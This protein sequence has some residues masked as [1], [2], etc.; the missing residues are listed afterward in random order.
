MAPV[1]LRA[2]L[3]SGN[4]AGS[5]RRRGVSWRSRRLERRASVAS[6]R[7]IDERAAEQACV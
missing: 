5:A 1:V 6:T 7:I 3:A 4:N 2:Y